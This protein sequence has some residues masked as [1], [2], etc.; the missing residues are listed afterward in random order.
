VTDRHRRQVALEVKLEPIDR[1]HEA[2]Q[3]DES[4]RSRPAAAESQGVGHHRALREA[5]EDGALR[6]DAGLPRE[7]VEPGAGALERREE[8][9]G[10]RVADPVD[11]VPVRAV[12]R[13]CERAAR[14][15]AEQAAVGVEH[16]EERR[17]VELVG[18][19]AVQEDERALGLAG[20]R[21]RPVDER[22]EAY[23]A[24]SAAA[25]SR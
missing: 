1:G 21:A 11:G 19:A 3:R 9:S 18:A 10:I 16:V 5:A 15:G 8:R 24:C 20:G 4:R 13:E 22:V 23:S 14:R 25:R 7:G 2:A 17:E 6:R 12:G